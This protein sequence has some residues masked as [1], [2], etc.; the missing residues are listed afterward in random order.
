MKK[1]GIIRTLLVFS[2][3]QKMNLLKRKVQI[4]W[5]TAMQFSQLIRNMPPMEPI[6]VKGRVFNS[7]I[8]SRLKSYVN[9]RRFQ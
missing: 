8:N 9:V 2:N 6:F 1:H 3:Q 5:Q 7:T 4:D